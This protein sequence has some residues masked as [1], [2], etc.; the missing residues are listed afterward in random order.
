MYVGPFISVSASYCHLPVFGSYLYINS[1]EAAAGDKAR[2]IS[3]PSR[4]SL[5]Y[6]TMCFQFWYHMNG[7]T[8]DSLSA[9]VIEEG[10]TADEDNRVFQMTGDHGDRWILEQVRMKLKIMCIE[11]Y[12][13]LV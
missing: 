9:H 12:L 10:G 5:G 4:M 7:A 13:D 11:A 2:I 1:D 8:I 6:D 3:P